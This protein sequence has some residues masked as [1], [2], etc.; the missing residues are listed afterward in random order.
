MMMSKFDKLVQY[1]LEA[2]GLQLGV[3][4]ISMIHRV[5]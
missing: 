2:S 4:E 1:I 5:V 3:Q